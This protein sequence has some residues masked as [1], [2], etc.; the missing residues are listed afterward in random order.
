[1]YSYALPSRKREAAGK[2]EAIYGSQNAVTGAM[3]VPWVSR[4]GF[5]G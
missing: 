4:V 5:E 2:I 3:G 1:M